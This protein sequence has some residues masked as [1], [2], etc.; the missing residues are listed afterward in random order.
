MGMNINRGFFRFKPNWKEEV[1]FNPQQETQ[2]LTAQPQTPGDM[3][4]KTQAPNPSV[5]DL[6]KL[7]Q[8]IDNPDIPKFS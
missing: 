5:A 8:M 2:K 4:P 3:T 1:K 6:Q 7:L